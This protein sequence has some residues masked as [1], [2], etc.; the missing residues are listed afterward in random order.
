MATSAGVERLEKNT[1]AKT[2][3][4]NDMNVLMM[5][6]QHQRGP[7]TLLIAVEQVCSILYISYSVQK[8]EPMLYQLANELC[9]QRSSDEQINRILT[10][11]TLL[12]MSVY[13]PIISSQFQT[14]DSPHATQLS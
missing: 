12:I 4:V 9:D 10:S 13:L 3:V 2:V 8:T 6:D 7:F 5:G 14:R 1:C 11:S